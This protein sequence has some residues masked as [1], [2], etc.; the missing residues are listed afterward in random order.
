ME[1]KNF[2][3]RVYSRREGINILRQFGEGARWLPADTGE[4]G[5]TLVKAAV[6]DADALVVR[7]SQEKDWQNYSSWEKGLKVIGRHGIGLDNIIWKQL[8]VQGKAVVNTPEANLSRWQNMSSPACFISA[9]SCPQW[10]KPPA[11]RCFQPF[12]FLPGLVVLNWVYPGT[13]RKNLGLVAR[14]RAYFAAW[15]AGDSRQRL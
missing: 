1:V 14:Y 10:I 13:I 11:L 9:K 7:S 2:A 3:Q 4:R 8:A 12:R 6:A 5:R 15:V